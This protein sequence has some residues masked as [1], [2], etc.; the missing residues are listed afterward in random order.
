MTSTPDTESYLQS[1]QN[2]ISSLQAK[3]Q[4]AKS[5]PL[6]NLE[7]SQNLFQ[8]K[9]NSSKLPVS[10][11]NRSNSLNYRLYRKNYSAENSPLRNPGNYLVTGT[12][13][14]PSATRLLLS[15]LG[16]S[17][18]LD[19][20]PNLSPNGG[21]VPSHK[22]SLVNNEDVLVG[23]LHI[24]NVGGNRPHLRHNSFDG[25]NV[26]E[27]FND[28]DQ[29]EDDFNNA[30]MTQSLNLKCNTNNVFDDSG[31]R[32]HRKSSSGQ[33]HLIDST[34][35]NVLSPSNQ[36]LNTVKFSHHR[37]LSDTYATHSS[38]NMPNKS[39]RITPKQDSQGSPIRRSSSFNVVNKNNNIYSLGSPVA[40]VSSAGKSRNLCHRPQDRLMQTSCEFA[41]RNNTP[42]IDC[43]S[44]DSDN[45]STGG[46]YSDY[47]R[48]SMRKTGNDLLAGARYNRA[49]VLRRARLESPDARVQH[50]NSPRCPS[51]PEMKRKFPTEQTKR[52]ARSQSRDSR[53]IG[54]VGRMT[55]VR[56]DVCQVSVS[57][58]NKNQKN[59]KMSDTSKQNVL[60]RLTRSTSV[61]KELTPKL[62]DKSMSESFFL[63]LYS[64]SFYNF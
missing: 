2:V 10:Q 15:N 61:A 43:M 6:S 64:V 51:T 38:H 4:N 39:Q 57:N 11:L 22:K 34:A 42:E 13:G 46:F 20:D 52:P 31:D 36:R 50:N 62:N 26:H 27:Y 1:T 21:Y 44:E 63:N 5:T 3:L 17:K 23:R 37:G 59:K 33:K 30:N 18:S 24:E 54:P 32:T 35:R 19:T 40:R 8:E 47:D 12:H 29:L 16:T 25:R 56:P 48:R 53:S 28:P 41:A 60:S 49:F 7:I 45:L 58:T 9:L 55:D 14:L